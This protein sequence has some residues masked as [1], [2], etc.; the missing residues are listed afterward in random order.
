[1]AIAIN[2]DVEESEKSRDE[3]SNFLKKRDEVASHEA[4]NDAAST[5]ANDDVDDAG[6][7][8]DLDLLGEPKPASVGAGNGVVGSGGMLA[9]MKKRCKDQESDEGYHESGGS[10]TSS[11]SSSS[12]A[13]SL[14][15]IPERESWS[16]KLDFLMSCIGFAVGLGN[17][18]RFPYLC[19]KNG[20]GAFLIPYFI[21]LIAGG[22]PVFFL[23]ISLGQFMQVSVHQ[24]LANFL[25]L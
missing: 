14:Q 17:I 12:A 16:G 4:R 5:T 10:S 9:M 21:C 18:W 15:K 19:Y 8:L 11:S 25:Q 22:L 1:M 7:R 23:E 20:G 3:G 13:S 2:S 24:S 6:Y